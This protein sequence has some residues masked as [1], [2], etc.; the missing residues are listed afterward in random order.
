[1]KSS[2]PDISGILSAKA[3][4]RQTL[5]ALSWEEKVAIV[6]QLQQL[7]PRGMWKDRAADKRNDRSR[8]RRPTA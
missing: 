1:M 5:A 4:R 3:Q 8:A 6:E 2:Y 7:L